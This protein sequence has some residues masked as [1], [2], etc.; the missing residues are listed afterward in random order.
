MCKAYHI[1]IY[2]NGAADILHTS[3]DGS[4]DFNVAN[5]VEQLQRVLKVSTYASALHPT[6]YS[7]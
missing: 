1:L 5:G 4:F 3:V 2:L 6:H 7:R